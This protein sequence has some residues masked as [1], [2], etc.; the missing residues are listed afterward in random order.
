MDPKPPRLTELDYPEKHANLLEKMDTGEISLGDVAREI[1]RR[2]KGRRRKTWLAIAGLFGGGGAGGTG[3]MK[4]LDAH[5]AVLVLEVRVRQQHHDLEVME[6][7]LD[8]ARLKLE[9]CC[10]R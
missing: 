6:R 7:Q 3:L 4:A 2:E 5:D 10:E 8:D 9:R 1:K